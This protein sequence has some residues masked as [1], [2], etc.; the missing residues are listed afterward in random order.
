M[1]S[2][3]KSKISKVF[4]VVFIALL[5]LA[6]AASAIAAAPA[7]AGVGQ[8][9]IEQS[10]S[11]SIMASIPLTYTTTSEYFADVGSAGNMIGVWV[12]VAVF[13]VIAVISFLV[14][15]FMRRK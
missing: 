3:L 12:I 10:L 8:F 5:G 4:M 11:G 14:A 13:V 7:P 15:I 2:F 6:F 1:K 9:A